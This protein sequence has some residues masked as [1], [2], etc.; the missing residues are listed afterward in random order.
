[1]S[2]LDW[3]LRRQPDPTVG[4]TASDGQLPRV[5][6]EPFAI[7]K[8][9][10]GDDVE[11]LRFLGRPDVCRRQKTPGFVQLDYTSHGYRFLFEDHKLAEVLF[12]IG[13]DTLSSADGGAPTCEVRLEDGGR[14]N[15][16]TTMSELAQRFGR[17]KSEDRDE[18]ETT[19][20]YVQ[21]GLFMDFEF[22]SAG[23]LAAWEISL[24]D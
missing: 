20:R 9:R 24:D 13:C 12:R 10:L 16:Q 22:N 14:L 3:F 8:V 19:W 23:K 18:D 5:R 4:W 15:D 7:G 17:P 2:L 11:A 6:F 1:M 21:P